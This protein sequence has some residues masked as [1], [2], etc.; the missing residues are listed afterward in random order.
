MGQEA[1]KSIVKSHY[2]GVAAILL[3][4]EIDRHDS[5]EKLGTWLR[6]IRDNTHDET[7]IYLVGT[8]LDL[9]DVRKVTKE[10]GE[11]YARSIGAAGFIEVSAKTGE[12]IK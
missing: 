4:Y 7:V 5:Y 10:E 8:K 2:K 1:F 11:V 3:F 9:E 12:N 6:E